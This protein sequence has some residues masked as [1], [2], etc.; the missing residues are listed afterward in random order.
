MARLLFMGLV[1]ALLLC[2]AMGSRADMSKA[3]AN[4]PP[5]TTTRAF[6]AEQL[7]ELEYKRQIAARRAQEQSNPSNAPANAP[8]HP[9]AQPVGAD[10]GP[11]TTTTAPTSS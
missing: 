5:A 9:P 11:A 7:K 4:T 10:G 2:G 1:G 6:T 8:A 3:P